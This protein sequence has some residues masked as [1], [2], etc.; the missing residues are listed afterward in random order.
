[1]CED[2]ERTDLV[3]VFEDDDGTFHKMIWCSY[4]AEGETLTGW[5]K[6]EYDREDVEVWTLPM[7]LLDREALC[8][9]CYYEEQTARRATMAEVSERIDARVTEN[10]Y[11]RLD[12]EE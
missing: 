1:M 8:I 11:D 10:V 3:T 4:S 7:G 2:E 9:E 5:C 12:D 6:D